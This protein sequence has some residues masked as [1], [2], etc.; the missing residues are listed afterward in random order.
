M[1]YIC[2]IYRTKAK[3]RLLEV[4]KDGDD[5]NYNEFD[6]YGKVIVK[7]PPQSW[8]YVEEVQRNERA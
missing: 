5:Y 4:I 6:R 3:E 8:C 7:R 2:D 1:N